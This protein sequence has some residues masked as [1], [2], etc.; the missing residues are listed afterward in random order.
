MWQLDKAKNEAELRKAIRGK[1]FATFLAGTP[2][3]GLGSPIGYGIQIA[4]GSV[5]FGFVSGVLLANLFGLIAFQVIWSFSNR[6]FYE[7]RFGGRSHRWAAQFRDLWP[8]QWRSVKIALFMNIFLIPLGWVVSMLLEWLLPQAS[9]YIP[10][11]FVMSASEAVF[12][13]TTTLR[14][15]GDL[16][17]KHARVMAAHYAPTLDSVQEAS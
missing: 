2:V 5:K 16:F 3:A 8:M 4:T 1:L 6:G 13:Q 17:E 12:I 11:G 7:R 15:L 14:L 9:R 10:L